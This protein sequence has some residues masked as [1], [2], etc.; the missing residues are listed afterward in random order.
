MPK[1]LLNL[2]SLAYVM[3]VYVMHVAE[4]IRWLVRYQRTIYDA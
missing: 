4:T 1:P 2:A 3:H